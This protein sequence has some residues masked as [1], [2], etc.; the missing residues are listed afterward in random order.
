MWGATIAPPKYK[1]S[2]IVTMVDKYWA[3][4]EAVTP[5]RNRIKNSKFSVAILYKVATINLLN[6]GDIYEIKCNLYN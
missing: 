1:E 6:S 3:V 5:L 2:Y 4:K